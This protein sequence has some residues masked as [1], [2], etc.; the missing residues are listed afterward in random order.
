MKT[1]FWWTLLKVRVGMRFWML[2]Y[3]LRGKTQYEAL[4][5]MV[6]RLM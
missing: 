2:W 4:H 1:P 5:A 6:D 3:R